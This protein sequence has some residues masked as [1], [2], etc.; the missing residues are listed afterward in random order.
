MRTTTSGVTPRFSMTFRCE[1][2]VPVAAP[3]EALVS[4]SIASLFPTAKTFSSLNSA[5]LDCGSDTSPPSTR[6]YDSL[7]VS[8]PPHVLHP[9]TTPSPSAR[10]ASAASSASEPVFSSTR[11]TSGPHACDGYVAAAPLR[12]TSHASGRCASFAR[13]SSLMCPPAFPRRSTISAPFFTSR[14]KCRQNSEYP[15]RSMSGRWRYPTWSFPNLATLVVR[16]RTA[17]LYRASSSLCIARTRTDTTS[18]RF[19]VPLAPAASAA[20]ASLPLVFLCFAPDPPERF[21]LSDAAAAGAISPVLRPPP[22]PPPPPRSPTLN[23]TITSAPPFPVNTSSTPTSSVNV[24]RFNAT[25]AS[26]TATFNPG[27]RS[28]PPVRSSH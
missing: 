1:A 13:S 11:T 20:V 4:G 26:P 18:P 21:F 14:G 3:V 9:T 7:V 23:V 28:A 19:S 15:V 17:S 25:I 16:S 12:G 22:P 6:P 8:S 5:T 10:N 24:T 2:A 27:L